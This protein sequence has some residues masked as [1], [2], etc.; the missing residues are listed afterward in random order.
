MTKLARFYDQALVIMQTETD[1][2]L[3]GFLDCRLEYCADKFCGT[4]DSFLF[5]WNC[6]KPEGHEEME[7][8]TTPLTTDIDVGGFKLL[9]LED[10]PVPERAKGHLEFFH[11]SGENSMYFYCDSEGFGFGAE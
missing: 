10:Q 4:G 2:V 1:E 9:G 7:R 6:L 5:G 11:S 8:E 3:G